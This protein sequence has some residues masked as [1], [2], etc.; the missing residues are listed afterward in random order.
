[1][2][3]RAGEETLSPRLPFSGPVEALEVAAEG[4]GGGMTR[5]REDQGEEGF[6]EPLRHILPTHGPLH[7][8]RHLEEENV[9][10]GIAVEGSSG[11]VALEGPE[12]PRLSGGVDQGTHFSKLKGLEG[13]SRGG[14]PLEEGLGRAQIAIAGVVGALGGALLLHGVEVAAAIVGVVLEGPT[15][16]NDHT[17][18]D[19]K[20]YGAIGRGS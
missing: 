19:Y 16:S 15:N 5:G 7:P 17:R 3:D 13:L 2:D 8:G 1:M 11:S 4:A 6:A 20:V 12:K 9:L 18:K 14:E 10:D